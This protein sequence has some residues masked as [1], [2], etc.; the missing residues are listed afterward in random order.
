MFQVVKDFI[1]AGCVVTEGKCALR[2]CKRVCP[3]CP[4]GL[5][6]SGPA[7]PCP[8]YV[9]CS[10]PTSIFP[11]PASEMLCRGVAGQVCPTALGAQGII[12]GC[13]VEN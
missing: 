11:F 6:S 12:H 8:P 10:P 7:S 13:A 9:F 1:N 3:L 2:H 4:E 5:Q